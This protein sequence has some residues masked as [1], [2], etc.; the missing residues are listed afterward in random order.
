M[1]TG[2]WTQEIPVSRDFWLSIVQMGGS[3]EDSLRFNDP[4]QNGGTRNDWEI[5]ADG[6]KH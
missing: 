6:A 5:A 4:K 1:A 2:A 3:P